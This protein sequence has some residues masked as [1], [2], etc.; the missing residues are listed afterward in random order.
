MRECT[1]DRSFDEEAD[2]LNQYG[3]EA[4]YDV[5]PLQAVD[6]E[7]AGSAIVMARTLLQW[8]GEPLR[9]QIRISSTPQ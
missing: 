8:V 5:R 3:S 9:E 2:G 7:E 6:A 1:G 4:R